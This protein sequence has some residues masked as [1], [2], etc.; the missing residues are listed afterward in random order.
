[1]SAKHAVLIVLS[2]FVGIFAIPQGASALSFTPSLGSPIAIAPPNDVVSNA[3]IGDFDGNGNDDIA[4]VGGNKG[5]HIYLTDSDGVGFTSGPGSPIGTGTSA[6]SRVGIYA[7]QFG[8]DSAVDLVSLT[9]S[10]P[11]VI[12]TYLGNGDGTFPDTPT[13]TYS[14]PQSPPNYPNTMGPGITGDVN[15]DGWPDIVLGLNHHSFSVALGSST[16]QFTS[17]GNA[18]EIPIAGASGGAALYP[19]AIGDWN[20][21]GNQ[22]LAFGLDDSNNSLPGV[23]TAMSDG[24][25]IPTFIGSGDPVLQ[26]GPYEWPSSIAT[27]DLNGDAADDLAV[28]TANNSSVKTLLGGGTGLTPNPASGGTFSDPGYPYALAIADYDQDGFEDIAVA[29]R[30]A[31]NVSVLESDGAGNL[32]EASGSPF[33]LPSVNGKL[34]SPNTLHTGDFNG[35]GVPDLASTSSHGGDT[36]QARGVDVLINRPEVSITPDPVEFPATRLNQT[37]AEQIVTIKNTGA[38]SVTLESLSKSGTDAAR[39][40]V[41][42][43]DCENTIAPGA[44]CHVGI[45]FT[46][47]AYGTPSASLDIE[48]TDIFNT[49]VTLIGNTPPYM[50]FVPP[51]GLDFGEVTS[52]YAPGTKTQTIVIYSGGGADLELGQPQIS[53]PDASDFEFED[54]FACANPLPFG[55]NCALDVKFAPDADASGYREAYVT[56]S[57]DNDPE[58]NEPIPLGGYAR[59]AEYSV[60]PSSRNFGKH[61]I[62]TNIAR[63]SQKFTV[64]STGAGSVAFNG[65]SITGPGADSY[66][67]FQN[68]C[69]QVDGVLVDTCS[70]VVEF[71]PKSGSPGSR[72]ATLVVDAFSSVAPGPVTASLTGQ[73][74]REVPERPEIRLRLKSA[75]KVKRGKTLVVN[76]V[77]TNLGRETIKSMTIKATVPKKLARAPRAVEVKNLAQDKSATRKLRIKVKKSARKGAKLKVKVVVTSGKAKKTAIRTITVR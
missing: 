25:P 46:P 28:A 42:G 55:S 71:D 19:A 59:K 2:V 11:S 32:T 76:A 4:M 65:V 30:G 40:D 53:G 54:P 43:T 73:A 63:P 22:D 77:V 34:F 50:D 18:I 33:G 6:S 37:S 3:A 29:N 68:S 5:I 35:D 38:P 13:S 47:T 56:F 52:G 57:S 64:T 72:N 20:G 36:N 58:D 12:E 49:S 7:G 14:V 48:L 26:Q 31:Q 17:G 16:G 74:I 24:Q 62:G 27:I 66:A 23:Y 69:P 41:V 51:M 44:E 60:T 61:V 70:F 10:S 75:G 21:D 1:M 39:F 45:T 67:I 8:G 15:S 9:Y